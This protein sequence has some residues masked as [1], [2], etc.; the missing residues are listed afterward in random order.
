MSDPSPVIVKDLPL[1]G[2]TAQHQ[3]DPT[4]HVFGVVATNPSDIPGTL[5][6]NRLPVQGAGWTLGRNDGHRFRMRR[7]R[8]SGVQVTRSVGVPT[9]ALARSAVVNPPGAFRVPSYHLLVTAST[10]EGN[11]QFRM[12]VGHTMDLLCGAV[13]IAVCGGGP[14][15]VVVAG[16]NIDVQQTGV[17]ADAVIKPSVSCIESAA[18]DRSVTNFCEMVRIPAATNLVIPVPSFATSVKVYASA[19]VAADWLTYI[20]DEGGPLVPC[21]RLDFGGNEYSN[22]ATSH[23]GAC[24]YLV[25][26]SALADRFCK[27]VWNIKP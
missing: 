1:L 5:V 27:I 7:I 17:I 13:D 9:S 12:C 14:T 16:Q 21:G 11:T 26:D 19:A 6:D 23:L 22:D 10:P 20:G 25:T 18:G 8:S 3:G 24:G 2:R 15:A 4:L